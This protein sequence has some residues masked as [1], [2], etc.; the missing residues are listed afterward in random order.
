MA[1]EQLHLLPSC[2]ATPPHLHG[3]APQNHYTGLL[4]SSSTP[5]S[6]NTAWDCQP[7]S[8]LPGQ[9]TGRDPLLPQ[10]NQ[11]CNGWLQLRLPSC[12]TNA[13]GDPVVFVW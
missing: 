4:A 6:M 2:W 11:W 3:T 7:L 8:A 5:E 1:L 12:V 10:D 9:G 13:R